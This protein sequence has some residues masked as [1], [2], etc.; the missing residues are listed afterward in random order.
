MARVVVV[1]DSKTYL[2]EW[3]ANAV[4]EGVKRVSGID[5]ELLKAG[6]SFSIMT[7]CKAD[8]MILGSPTHYN[9]VTREMRA[10][11]DAVKR[12][13][14]Q[15]KDEF[16]PKIG[17]VFGSYAWDGGWVIEKLGEEM[18]TLGVKLVSPV[19]LAVDRNREPGM[20]VYER[21]DEESLE[22]C[23]ELGRAV[24]MEVS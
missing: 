14:T 4:V 7:L 16:S 20:K 6:T 18:K 12:L 13:K 19:V 1:Y 10:V 24:A 9:D 3:M 5:V 2:T 21:I 23:R 17:G 22:R 8:A 15:M 11:L